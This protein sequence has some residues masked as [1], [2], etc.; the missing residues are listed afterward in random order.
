MSVCLSI[1]HLPSIYHLSSILV[2]AGAFPDSLTSC[3]HDA[4]SRVVWRSACYYMG[5]PEGTVAAQTVPLPCAAHH[6]MVLTKTKLP[7]LC[8]LKSYLLPF[9]TCLVASC[10]GLSELRIWEMGKA[11]TFVAE[12][13]QLWFW[14]QITLLF[15][16]W[17][18]LVKLLMC[19]FPCL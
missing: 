1:Y 15:P 14:N 9:S 6:S 2:W 19:Q 4:G 8:P 11:L 3:L 17:A 13:F 10:P 5:S 7:L 18:T 16:S 12:G